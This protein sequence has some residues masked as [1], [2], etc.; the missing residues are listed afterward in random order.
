MISHLRAEDCLTSPRG[1]PSSAST[2]CDVGANFSQEFGKVFQILAGWHF[3]RTPQRDHQ[4]PQL[5]R[6]SAFA[7]G[8]PSIFSESE[9][10]KGIS[11]KL[12]RSCSRRISRFSPGRCAKYVLKADSNAECYGCGVTPLVSLATLSSS[13][14]LAFQW[15][16]S[17]CRFVASKSCTTRSIASFRRGLPLAG[18]ESA[19]CCIPT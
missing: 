1:Q 15:A 10:P 14:S 7:H 18:I 9:V 5:L 4:R 16:A 6:R 19:R 12:Y 8:T 13:A 11:D 2:S 3:L 17:S